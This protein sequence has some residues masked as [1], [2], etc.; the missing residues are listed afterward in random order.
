[1]RIWDK[2]RLNNNDV[3]HGP[4]LMLVYKSGKQKITFIEKYIVARYTAK[5]TLT[6]VERESYKERIEDEKRSG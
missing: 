3:T 1:M 4:P 2:A 6:L 5:S